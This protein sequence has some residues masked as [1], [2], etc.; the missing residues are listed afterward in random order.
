MLVDI[1]TDL[2]HL[3]SGSYW[4][5]KYYISFS[6]QLHF[7]K[8]YNLMRNRHVF[9]MDIIA[10]FKSILLSFFIWI[11]EYWG[12]SFD[13]NSII[14]K[15]LHEQFLCNKGYLHNFLVPFMY[16]NIKM[17]TYSFNLQFCLI[18]SYYMC[19]FQMCTRLSL[20]EVV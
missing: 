19:H 16:L 7:L 11:F 18:S 15:I 10:K 1:F 12:L 8:A 5:S 20:S 13:F 9:L 3:Y 4:Y 2:Y 17:Q 14:S 6:N